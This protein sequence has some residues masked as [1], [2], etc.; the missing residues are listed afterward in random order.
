MKAQPNISLDMGLGPGFKGG[1]VRFRQR[2]RVPWLGLDDLRLLYRNDID[3]EWK[4]IF[5]LFPDRTQAAL[6][7]RLH[8]L[9]RK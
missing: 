9:Q 5:E 4:D 7:A 3:M 8:M 1:D 6:R 2:T